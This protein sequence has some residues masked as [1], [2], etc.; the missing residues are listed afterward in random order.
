MAKLTALGA[1]QEVG[2]SSFL[3]DVGEKILLDRGVK[4]GK[5]EVEYPLPVKTNLDAVVISHAHLDHSGAL[6]ELFNKSNSFV[7]MTMP[8][9]E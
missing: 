8:T 2:R 1:S 6:P 5:D 3:L 7:Y 9:L 4:L